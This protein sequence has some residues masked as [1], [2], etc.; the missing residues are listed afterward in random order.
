[1]RHEAETFTLE[2]VRS[3]IEKE[4]DAKGITWGELE[5]SDLHEWCCIREYDD[6]LDFVCS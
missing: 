5:A 4:I 3:A 2:D 1:M 6:R